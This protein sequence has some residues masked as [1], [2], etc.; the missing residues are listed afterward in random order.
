MLRILVIGDN[1]KL[2]ELYRSNEATCVSHF[3]D[4]VAKPHG[5]APVVFE[6]LLFIL[7]GLNIC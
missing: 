2:Y 4:G 3:S 5:K 1:W 6:I 7:G